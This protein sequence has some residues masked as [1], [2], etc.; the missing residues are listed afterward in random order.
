MHIY[1]S[2]FL[3]RGEVWY[4][5]E[6]DAAPVDWILYRQRS[7]PVPRARCDQFY[8]ILLDLRPTL[9][10]LSARL[11]K[12][13]AYKIRRAERGDGVRCEVRW[14]AQSPDLDGFEAVYQRFAPMK[15]LDP[16]DRPFLDQLAGAAC[17]ELSMAR[18]AAGAPLAHHV[19]YRDRSRSCLL[20]SVSLYQMAAESGVRNALGRAN[21]YLFWRDLIRHKEQGLEFFDF[22]GWYP[23]RTNSELLNINRFKEEFGGQVTCEYNCRQPITLKARV[24]LGTAAILDQRQRL[25]ARLRPPVGMAAG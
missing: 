21:R 7:R 19:Y 16:L 2:R 15:G 14:P 1:K 12:S 20:H 6:P 3:V 8:T 9:K 23:G 18:D 17:L 25:I 13:A 11:S 10:E 5:H 4:D 24:A 22:G